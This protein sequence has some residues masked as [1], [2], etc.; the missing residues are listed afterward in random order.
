MTMWTRIVMA[1]VAVVMALT[2]PVL[3]AGNFNSDNAY[4]Y[5]SAQYCFPGFD[6][7]ASAT[8]IYC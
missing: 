1:L 6:D 5:K 7:L 8:R 2:F 4:T 3:A